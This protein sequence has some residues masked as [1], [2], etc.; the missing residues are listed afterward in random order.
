MD[1]PQLPTNLFN[2]IKVDGAP[3]PDGVGAIKTEEIGTIP[4]Y[5]GTVYTPAFPGPPPLG[6]VDDPGEFESDVVVV[7]PPPLSLPDVSAPY[8]SPILI[9]D[10]PTLDIPEWDTPAPDFSSTKPPVGQF[11]FTEVPYGSN[12]LDQTTDLISQ[13]EAGG[14]GIPDFIWDTIWGKSADQIT[15][16][17]DKQIDE[18]NKE[19]SSRGFSLPQGAQ[20][21][22]V[23]EIRQGI[24]EEQSKSSRENAIVYAQDEVK[25]LQFAVQQGIALENIKGQ[26]HQAEMDRA[27]KMAENV[28]SAIYKNF[29]ADMAFNNLILQQYSAEAEVYKTLI[30]AEVT[31]LESVKLEIQSQE[32]ILKANDT[33]LNQYEIDIKALS[34][35]IE[36]YN[37]SVGAASVMYE[38]L[39]A[40]VAV[41]AEEI[42]A[43][44][45]RIEA[46]TQKVNV[47]KETVAAEGIK[48]DAY[49]TSVRAYGE[50]VKAF[51]IKVDANSK[52]ADTQVAIEKLSIDSY[53]SQIKGYQAELAAKSEVQKANVDYYNAYI[54]ANSALID[55]NKTATSAVIESDKNRIQFSQ[56]ENEASRSAAELASRASEA[57][58][59]IHVDTN[60]TLAQIN[61]Q[62][63]GSM[64]SS[65]NIG[66]NISESVSGSVSSS[67]AV[68]YFGGDV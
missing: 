62:L 19:W 7:L 1:I 54:T 16:V 31:R 40:E 13:M 45:A 63:A 39:K 15:K 8:L 34:L 61:A 14:V 67:N 53:D 23:L 48:V 35:D 11:N 25:N 52:S 2:P 49:E 17:G 27:F 46:Q 58:A 12:L 57:S 9:P 42:K 51:G 6:E 5:T 37:A 66:A 64:F 47:Y 24:L 60:T 28:L 36:Q 18:V 33:L 43:Y 10:V 22:Q 68:S 55:D 20:A 4:E 29:E 56:V 59:K 50:E 30:D 32:L 41:Y 21:G 38:G 65:L 26:W 3:Q 44:V